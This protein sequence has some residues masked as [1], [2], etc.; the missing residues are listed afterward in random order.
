MIAGVIGGA[1]G[2]STDFA[3]PPRQMLLR[4]GGSFRRTDVIDV[5]RCSFR[6]GKQNSIGPHGISAASRAQAFADMAAG[7]AANRTATESV[8][9]YI[10]WGWWT[11]LIKVFLSTQDLLRKILIQQILWYKNANRLW[12]LSGQSEQ[13]QHQ[14]AWLFCKALLY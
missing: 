9:F 4:H 6:G 10:H 3:S 2:P 7:W 14:V 13:D 5:F 12:Y 11:K 1:Q 8:G